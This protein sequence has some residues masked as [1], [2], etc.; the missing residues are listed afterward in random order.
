M[1]QLILFRHAKAVP[2][3]AIEDHARGLSPRGLAEAAE[4]GL[5]LDERL[6]PDLALVSDAR[7]TRETFGRVVEAIGRDIPHR[8]ERALYDAGAE[9][10]AEVIAT[11]DPEAT[12]LLVVGHNP[13][14]GALARQLAGEGSD[15]ARL[16]LAA[17]FPT[18][19][20]AIF[21][22][23]WTSWSAKEPGT[24]REFVTVDSHEGSD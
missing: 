5:S 14:I 21:D 15:A 24:L 17:G 9:Q 23:P 3:T 10:I 11:V 6:H 1:R 19:A 8:F 16:R 20:Y 12:C 22:L 2:G 7:R 18:S 13:G 4:A